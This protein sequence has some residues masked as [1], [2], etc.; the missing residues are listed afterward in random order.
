MSRTYSHDEAAQLIPWLVNGTLPETER[1]EVDRHVRACVPCRIALQEQQQLRALVRSQP[2]VPLPAE[3][4]F[5][6][7]GGEILR[8]RRRRPAPPLFNRAVTATVL[9]VSL[10]VASLLATLGER[11]GED[12]FVTLSD[13]PDGIAEIDVV[14]ADGVSEAQARALVQSLG[15]EIAS[16]PSELGR[17]R[18]RANAQ[19]PDA[20]R[21]EAILRDLSEHDGVRFAARAVSGSAQ[22]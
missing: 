10:G 8:R 16:G 6:R 21:I 22:P 4:A 2:I 15:G 9:V 13:A 14:F 20:K 1:A 5:D 3:P 7:L 18:I 19:A 11:A 17:Y 12:P